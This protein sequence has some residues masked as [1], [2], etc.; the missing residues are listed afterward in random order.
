VDT[1]VSELPMNC[2]DRANI[3]IIGTKN[4]RFVLFNFVMRFAIRVIFKNIFIYHRGTKGSFQYPIL[5]FE[6]GALVHLIDVKLNAPNDTP[7]VVTGA[8]LV[9]QTD[10]SPGSETGTYELRKMAKTTTTGELQPVSATCTM[11]RCTI[12]Y[13]DVGVYDGSIA[14][15]TDCHFT[16][17]G[18]RRGIECSRNSSIKAS[19]CSFTTCKVLIMNN[20]LGNFQ[21]CNFESDPDLPHFSSDGVA[22]ESG[23]RV[24]INRCSF[25]KLDTAVYVK[26]FDSKAIIQKSVFLEKIMKLVTIRANGNCD[27]SHNQVHC[28]GNF[29]LI[30]VIEGQVKI[31]AN[32]FRR[33]PKIAKDKFSTIPIHDMKRLKVDDILDKELNFHNF[34]RSTKSAFMEQ[35]K[36][37]LSAPDGGSNRCNFY[38]DL[39]HKSCERCSICENTTGQRLN[40]QLPKFKYC[41]KCKHAS[42]CSEECQVIDWRDHQ[43]E[44]YRTLNAEESPEEQR[45]RWKKGEEKLE[46]K[47]LKRQKEGMERKK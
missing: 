30:V 2:L 32:K 25:D 8:K 37:N 9:R 11:V 22:V 6:P 43:Y 14:E 23:G 26:N 3:E 18:H 16:G 5:L 47:L 33:K 31:I 17:F 41:K 21:K 44:C 15:F 46:A 1:D 29:V 40:G 35:A 20:S 4:V 12:F 39:R 10:G 38:R 13:G 28:Q 34:S 24:E 7:V 45:A 42:Y 27:F 36:Q 19:N